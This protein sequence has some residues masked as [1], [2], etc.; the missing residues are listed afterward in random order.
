M[1]A[2]TPIRTVFTSGNATGLAEFQSGEFIAL[3]HGGLG[4]S[5]SIGSA[6]QVLKVN[7]GASALEF[8]NVEA[9]IN[10][11][12]MTDGTSITLA[13]SD[14]F[15]VS[16]GGTEKR[17][18]ASQIKTYVAPT[19]GATAITSLDIDGGT[20]IGAALTTSDLLIV[21]DGAG[22][23][24]RKTALSRLV[25]LMESEIDSIG[26]NLTVTGNLTVNG[27][28]TTVNSTTTTVDDPIF[29]L[30]GDTAP[31]SDDDKDRG[32]EFRY[33]TGSAAKIGFFGFDDSANAFTFIADA[34]NSSEVFSGS[35]GNVVFGT[36]TSD[37]LT[38][39]TDVLHVDATNDRVGINTTSPTQALTIDGGSSA[40]IAFL[41]GGFQSIYY[42]DSG[43]AT[44]GFVHYD[45]SS[46][47][48]Q[49]DV[50]GTITLDAPTSIKLADNG[51][52]FG[53]FEDS[54]NDFVISSI[55]SDKDLIFKGS[56]GG[57]TITAL[58]LDMSEAGDATFNNQV[59]VG[60]GKLVLNS[61]AVTSTAAELNLLD[62]RDA[63]HLAV[64][65]KIEG[66]DFTGSLLIGHATSG[67]LSSSIRNTGVGLVALDAL[68]SGT[69]NTA[70]GYNSQSSMTTGTSN[71]AIGSTALVTS[72]NSS[73]N[74][75][76]GFN[77]MRDASSGG[78]NT[79]VGS[80]AG[81]VM[82]GGSAANNI[83]IGFQAGQNISSGAGN[84]V[85]GTANVDTATGDRQLVIAGND[86]STTT[87]WIKGSSSGAVTLS[88]AYTFPTSDGSD[89][90]VLKTDGS[91]TL[92]FGDA[93]SSGFVESTI[94]VTPGS[95]D[96]DL[97]KANNTGS[98]ETP[99]QAQNGSFGQVIRHLYD[100]MEPKGASTA[101][102]TDLGSSE[103]H[104][105]A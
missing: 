77:A 16:D 69:N 94:T 24:N 95:V 27:T 20:D 54:S 90:Q 97:T 52:Q 101:N 38:V 65:G 75:A 70:V 9:V 98:S 68:T 78:Q 82:S 104:V 43:N 47:N 85:I 89:G 14:A 61:T 81:L 102:N 100:L 12:G 76:I 3:T 28:T 7:S 99:F 48:Y 88:G 93:A 57:S 26:G 73:N 62:G 96:F 18:T 53:Q 103:S 19:A 32:I 23:T 21:D 67:T 29:T 35:A 64:P 105:G 71:T 11:D 74:T 36:V 55:V 86:G 2:K 87:T 33:H 30:G 72:T 42:G 58:T 41:G 4:A 44:A 80:Q 45:H 56:D 8:G 31:G 39:D 50:S 83:A 91:G 22:G 60:D 17:I 13:D 5:L 66:T 6:G 10:I 92:T 63:T 49:I 79:V 25:T 37:G 15:A 84:I 40:K 51:T 46:D 59:I 34:T 1:S